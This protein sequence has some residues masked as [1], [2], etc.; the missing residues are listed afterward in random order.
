MLGLFKSHDTITVL[1]S[2]KGWHI[3]SWILR[4]AVAHKTMN[5]ALVP[6][7]VFHS[8][9]E[10]MP[11]VPRVVLQVYNSSVMLFHM[12]TSFNPFFKTNSIM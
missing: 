6:L 12:I 1:T 8:T 9:G 3:A 5:G 11:T 10:F 2:C 7:A 4:N